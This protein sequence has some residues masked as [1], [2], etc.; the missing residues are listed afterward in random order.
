MTARVRALYVLTRLVLTLDLLGMT[1]IQCRSANRMRRH[2]FLSGWSRLVS[3]KS[4]CTLLKQKH[5]TQRFIPASSFVQFIKNTSEHTTV[6]SLESVTYSVT[7]YRWRVCFIPSRVRR[8]GLSSYH[9]N[10]CGVL[11]IT[12]NRRQA[13]P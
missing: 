11:L 5:I 10:L 2:P 8:E 13:C 1:V 4:R 9:H 3:C 7:S 6:A 12:R